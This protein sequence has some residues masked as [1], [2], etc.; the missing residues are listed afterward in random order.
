M[1]LSTVNKTRAFLLPV[2]ILI[3][4]L[5]LTQTAFSQVDIIGS[6]QTGRMMCSP[7]S[8]AT[9]PRTGGVVGGFDANEMLYFNRPG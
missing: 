9:L 7:I 8:G 2:I 6:W 5:C 1:N 4:G 3:A